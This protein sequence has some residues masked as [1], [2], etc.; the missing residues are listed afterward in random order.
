MSTGEYF[1]FIEGKSVM[2][3]KEELLNLSCVIRIIST[4]ETPYAFSESEVNSFRNSI[5]KKDNSI[6]FKRGDIVYVKDGCFKNLF[7]LVLGN[8]DENIRVLF[9]FHVRNFIE[10]LEPKILRKDKNI[11]SSQPPNIDKKDWFKKFTE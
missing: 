1:I 7:G 6:S 3:K 4:G 10:L 5:V 11:F 9:K 2:R 8:K